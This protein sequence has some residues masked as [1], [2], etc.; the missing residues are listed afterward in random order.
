MNRIDMPD[1]DFQMLTNRGRR[2]TFYK[3]CGPPPLLDSRVYTPK[4]GER[5][6]GLMWG[7]RASSTGRYTA[8]V[9]IFWSF[10]ILCR[11][12]GIEGRTS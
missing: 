7:T 8:V 11:P 3:D 4:P 1:T 6:A 9:D 10:G 2:V 5:I 12:A